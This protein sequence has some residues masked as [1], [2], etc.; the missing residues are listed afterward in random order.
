MTDADLISDSKLNDLIEK[1]LDLKSRINFVDLDFQ[2]YEN[3]KI[4]VQV[5][6]GMIK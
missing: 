2:R 6:T 1:G 3:E 4:P 5:F